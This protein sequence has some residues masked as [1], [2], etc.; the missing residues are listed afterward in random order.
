MTMSLRPIT[1]G[2]L[3][4]TDSL[5]LV[6]AHEQGFAAAEGIELTLVRETSWANIRDRI[7]VG[8][9]DVAH[10]LAPMPI[11]ANLGLAPLPVR[12]IAPM[13]LGHGGNAITVSMALW[14]QM[15]DQGAPNE[16]D[17]AANAAAL[18]RV[19]KTSGPKRR[20]G[21]VHQNSSHNYELRYWL[22]A[23]GII[24][25]RD[26]E[27]VVLPPPLLPDALR[28]GAIDG[29]CVGEPWNSV[30]VASVAGRIVA[31]KSQIWRDSPDKVLGMRE[32]WGEAEPDLVDALLRALHHT[33]IWCADPANRA[34]IA[35]TMARPS[36]LDKP[37]DLIMH[38][39]TG[40]FPLG[41]GQSATLPDFYCPDANFPDR[42]DA[43]W[44]YTQMAR[45]GDVEA[46]YTNA[47]L[48]GL[49]FRPDIYRRALAPFGLAT[50]AGADKSNRLFDGLVFDTGD[51]EPHISRR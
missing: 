18:G 1:A 17:V 19:I 48:A 46:S 26:V 41:D 38:A 31:T 47:K 27:I 32:S 37:A 24:A 6:M 8:H 11:A 29:Y 10:M 44:F 39:L 43:L 25:D 12:L 30:G 20:F 9:F 22:A 36:Y 35:E 42:A 3:P 28:E 21:V 5:L 40:Q 16:L 2:F 45:W 15:Q 34:A 50:R 33:A 51:L 23:A 14:R 7:G 49:S 4:L 13:V